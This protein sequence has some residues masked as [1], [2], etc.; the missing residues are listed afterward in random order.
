MNTTDSVA[1]FMKGGAID[2]Y[3][4]ICFG[5]VVAIEEAEIEIHRLFVLRVLDVRA[6]VRRAYQG[7][8]ALG[9]KDV[10]C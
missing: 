8:V 3:T 7:I 9:S 4:V 6:Q 1:K 2:L 10:S 5:V